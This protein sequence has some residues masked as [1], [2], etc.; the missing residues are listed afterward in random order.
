[1]YEATDANEWAFVIDSYD[2]TWL[3][4][5]EIDLSKTN[6]CGDA[7]LSVAYDTDETGYVTLKHDPGFDLNYFEINREGLS[8]TDIV[9]T[10]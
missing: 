6:I 4:L 3:V 2:D 5:S 7:V 9:V 1:M 8:E 10:V